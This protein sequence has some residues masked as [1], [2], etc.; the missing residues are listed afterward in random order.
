[1]RHLDPPCR[2]W[3]APD[4]PTQNYAEFWVQSLSDMHC[5][6]FP[7]EEQPNNLTHVE[8]MQAA[9]ILAA[10]AS[11]PAPVEVPPTVRDA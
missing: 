9:A 7:P 11:M 10:G 1:M 8:I 4:R 5:Y 3:Y 2:S 6:Q